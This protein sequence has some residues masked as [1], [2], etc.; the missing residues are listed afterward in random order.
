MS[1]HLIGG[2]GDL[3]RELLRLH[4]R[5]NELPAVLAAHMEAVLVR[6]DAFRGLPI[7]SLFGSRSHALRVL[8]SAWHR[9][10]T[11]MGIAAP[12]IGDPF[13]DDYADAIPVPFEDPGIWSTVDSMF[14]E[15]TL[16]PLEVAWLP[17]DFPGK[18]R[19][20]VV[21]NPGD[22]RD[23]VV[24]GLKALAD[25]LPN[26]HGSHRDWLQYAS[27]L[28]ELLSR[29]HALDNAR[30]EA[31]R[32]QV[33]AFQFTADV[34]LQEWVRHHYADLPSLSAV[35]APV[36]LHHVP[37]FLAMRRD[38]GESK[39]AL[40]VFDGLA[41]DQW[42]RIREHVVAGIP[43]VSF[44]ETACFAWLP[45]LTS[46]SR[47]AIFSGLKPREFA[48]SIETTAQEPILWSRFWAKKNQLDRYASDRV[49]PMIGWVCSSLNSPMNGDRT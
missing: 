29:F 26:E 37:R 5:G 2:I 17:T 27:K 39:I 12:S 28:G 4:Y 16:Q 6:L 14:L 40:L 18:L 20:G 47:Q 10:L 32:H 33:E 48:S 35:K 23:L 42:A 3:W 19:V 9:H 1:P 8:Q 7:A 41:V 46:V 45:T 21:R 24:E 31:V 13:P 34:R 44:D 49:P 38:A 11:T 22:L 43:N 30:F 15:G 36:M 25:E